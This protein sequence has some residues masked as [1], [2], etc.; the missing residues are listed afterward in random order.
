MVKS[1]LMS[2]SNAIPVLSSPLARLRLR[3]G[4]ALLAGAGVLFLGF[5]L[6]GW[7][8]SAEQAFQWLAVASLANGYLLL[9][10]WR[11]LPQNHRAGETALLPTFGPGNVLSLAR[12]FLMMALVGFLF[13]PQPGNGDPSAWRAWAPGLLYTC[14]ALPDYL[15]GYLA[16]R[17][18]HVTGLGAWLDITLDSA[19]VLTA[20]LLAAQY[21]VLPWWY[22]PIGLARYLFLAGIWARERLGLPVYELPYSVRR[23]G[24]AALKMGFLFV[25]LLP[26]FRPPATHLG[27]AAF[28]VPFAAGFLWD[29]LIVSG[30]LPAG[31]GGRFPGVQRVVSSWLPWLPRLLACGLGLFGAVRLLESGTPGL[32]VG[33]EVAAAGLIGL[34]VWPRLAAILA[35]SAAGLGQWFV[36]LGF[37]RHLA[38][39]AY[40]AVIFLGSG[41]GSLWPFEERL[42]AR[43]PGERAEG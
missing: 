8:W 14:A 38:I 6:A 3:W 40:I 41:A 22:V 20:T 11:N 25:I 43:R 18:N 9:G 26:L 4:L 30:A 42:L 1:L 7:L 10:L 35:V 34:G 33:V 15:D 17:A 2:V 12:G 21:G 31:A 16:R 36:P 32:L 5:Q 27:A 39:L 13:L 28:G 23:R 29:W 37:E 24:F 19:G